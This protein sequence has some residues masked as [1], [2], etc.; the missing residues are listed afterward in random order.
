MSQAPQTRGAS[1]RGAHSGYEAVAKGLGWFSIGLGLVELLAPRALCRAIGLEGREALV[2][3]Y[4]VRETMTGVAILM[5]HDPTPWIYGR[6][7]GDALDLATLAID[8]PE[9]DAQRAGRALAAVAVAGVTL[10]DIVCAK[11]LSDDK[12]LSKPET[13]DYGDRAGFPRPP[14]AM[15]GAASDFEMPDDF[16][17]PDPLRPWQDGRPA[18]GTSASPVAS[19]P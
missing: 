17:V 11:G 10:V 3:G 12:R 13:Y 4:G 2:R 19:T 15:R 16:R 6:V 7:A 9:D 18:P 5:S 1:G 8:V 14:G